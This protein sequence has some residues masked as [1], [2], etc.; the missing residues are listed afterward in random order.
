MKMNDTT[1]QDV[2]LLRKIKSRYKQVERLSTQEYFDSGNHSNFPKTE[3]DRKQAEINIKGLAYIFNKYKVVSKDD[4]ITGMRLCNSMRKK[5]KL[6]VDHIRT[7]RTKGGGI[8]FLSAPYHPN[9]EE[10]LNQGFNIE[11][12]FYSKNVM[13]FAKHYN[14]ISEVRDWVYIENLLD[15]R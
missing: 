8:L 1:K 3:T 7:W 10:Y 15:K 2:I 11:P 9:E 6:K 13:T 5:D 12:S 14:S 4:T